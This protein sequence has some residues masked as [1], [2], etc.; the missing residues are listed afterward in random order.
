MA[1]VHRAVAALLPRPVTSIGE[2][3]VDLVFAN[4][5]A[6][7]LIPDAVE[8]FIDQWTALSADGARS[9]DAIAFFL[10]QQP[11][12]DRVRFGIPWLEKVEAAR[13]GALVGHTWSLWGWIEE[14][15]RSGVLSSA[16]TARVRNLVDR[17]V[18]AGNRQA[19]SAQAILDE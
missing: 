13:G 17:A 7:W 11:M 2:E 8:P 9:A 16:D 19:L 18:A 15:L 12:A 6:N 14:I 4:A 5:Y 10:L 3:N 1:S